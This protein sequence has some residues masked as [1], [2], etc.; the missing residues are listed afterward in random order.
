[1]MI[2]GSLAALALGVTTSI[3]ILFEGE[4]TDIMRESAHEMVEESK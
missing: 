2:L 4:L 3:F 1:M